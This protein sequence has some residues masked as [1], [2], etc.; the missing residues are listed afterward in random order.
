MHLSILREY[1]SLDFAYGID[2]ALDPERIVDD[3]VFL[4]FLVGNDFLPHLP[5]LDISEMAFDVLINAYKEVMTLKP[6]SYI[7]ENGEIGDLERLEML[8][9]N[10]PYDQ[11][12]L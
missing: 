8:L 1:L 11:P 4:T 5:T 12:S 9:G 7:V 10:L 6:G 3:F 2:G